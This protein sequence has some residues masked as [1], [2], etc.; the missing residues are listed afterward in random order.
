VNKDLEV[1]VV[2]LVRLDLKGSED[3][4]DEMG[5][6][7]SQDQLDQRANQDCKAFLGYQETKETE[8]TR[9]TLG[10]RELRDHGACQ[11]RMD[12]LAWP[13]FLERWGPEGSLDH[14]DSTVCLDLL[15][16]LAQ[17]EGRDLKETK[18]QM[19]RLALL[20]LLDKRDPLDLLDQLDHWDPLGKLDLAGSQDF[21]VSQGL[22]GYPATMGTLE[23]LD[24]KE[25]RVPKDTLGL[26]ASQALG[27]SKEIL[28]NGDNKGTRETKEKLGWRD[29]RVTWG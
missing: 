7:G 23:D 15:E 19:D 26:L 28:A 22:M 29:K 1:P 18:D 12:P 20:D 6:V 9:V 17:R 13:V 14:A 3:G 27:E 16:Y 5:S 4:L 2:W 10:P 24:Q 25:T 11:A 21:L 8:A